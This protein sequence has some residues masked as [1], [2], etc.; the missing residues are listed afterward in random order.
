M[1]TVEL[2]RQGLQWVEQLGNV[3]VECNDCFACDNLAHKL[4]IFDDT[5]ATHKEQAKYR[6]NVEHVHQ[7]TED[8][9]HH[10]LTV[11]CLVQLV[12]LFNKL[13]HLGILAVED[14][15]NLHTGKV[16]R[17]VGVD[18]GVAILY[19][20]VSPTRELAEDNGK[21]HDKWH[22]AQNHQSKQVVD[23]NHHYHNA[24]NN[25]AVLHQVYK[26]TCKHL[27]DCVGIVGYACY[28][29]ANGDFGQ[30]RVGQTFDMHKCIFAKFGHD[31]LSNR[32]QNERLEVGASKGYK[33]NCHVQHYSQNQVTHFESSG[34]FD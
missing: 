34:I 3:H 2:F 1:Q 6:A 12:V 20:A 18:I 24:H 29:F 21:Q 8:T 30:L 27:R 7:W 17:K 26:H 10:D 14:L 31:L 25:K 13:V 11:D 19:L 16:F 22:K 9:K 32:L 33:Q 4:G 5:T 28:Q 23:G 15:G